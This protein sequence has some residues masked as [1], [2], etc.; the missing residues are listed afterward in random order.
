[1]SVHAVL[2]GLRWAALAAAAGPLVY[3]AL[4]IYCGWDF[5]RGEHRRKAVASSH[6]PPASILKPVRGVDHG[7]YENF[8]SFCRL[9]YPEYEILFAVGDDD[10]PVIPLVEKLRRDFPERQI[11]L[12]TGIEQL[13]P[14][15]KVNNL[16]R[17]T[18]EARHGLLVM[19]DSDVRVEPNY[20]REVAAPIADAQ[21]GAVTSFFR[22]QVE[23]SLGAEFEALVLAAETVPNALVAR[24]I[25]GKVQFAFGWTMATTKKHLEAIGGFEAMVY[26]HSDDFEFGNRIS[27]LGL[28][29]ELLRTPVTMVFPRETMKEFLQHELRWAIGLRNVRPAGYVGLLMTFGLPWAVLAAALAPSISLAAGYLGAY[30]A[31]RLLLVWTV[32]VW[33]LG[34]PVTRRSLWLVPL[35]DAINF[36]VW[37]AGF[38]ASKIRWRGI[39]YRVKKGLLVRVSKESASAAE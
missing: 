28:R 35:R 31:L 22:G 3:Y 7:A 16:C 17:L 39:E 38:F 24:K 21:V 18:R 25:E 14:N 8:A 5:F 4:A 29:I 23:G 26:H 32:G 33:G 2:Q 10:D 15:R 20:L 27:A 1:M 34:D 12:L 37:V 36:V 9:D 11:R 30:L 19:S 6:T 13:G